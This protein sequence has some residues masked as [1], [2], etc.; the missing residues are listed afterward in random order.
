MMALDN[1]AALHTDK[2]SVEAGLEN[3][4]VL[5]HTGSFEA[6]GEERK[7]LCLLSDG[8]LLVAEGQHLNSHVLS[9]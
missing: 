5:S 9:Y 4:V 3:A 8:R 2:A 6:S 1:V 7:L